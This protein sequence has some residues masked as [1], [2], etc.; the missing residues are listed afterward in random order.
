MNDINSNDESM[1]YDEMETLLGASVDKCLILR[2]ENLD[3]KAKNS[4]IEEYLNKA[5][6][7][8][9]TMKVK[10]S[11]YEPT[12]NEENKLKINNFKGFL[13][14]SEDKIKELE[15]KKINEM[16]SKY[17]ELYASKYANRFN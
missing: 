15:T 11:K 8:N 9:D 10:L 13:S 2:E 12:F 16:K 5:I 14:M 17:S 1:T 4:V 3:L 6:D 7:Q